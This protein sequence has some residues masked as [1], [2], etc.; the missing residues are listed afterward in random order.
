MPNIQ[1][2]TLERHARLRW[3]RRSNYLFAAR[4]PLAPLVGFEMHSAAAALPI[5]F[6]AHGEGWVVAAIL[7]VPPSSNF[8]VAP[9]GR[10]TGPYIP[11]VLRSNPFSLTKTPNGQLLLCI[12]EDSGLVTEGPQGER[13]FSDDG[14]PAPATTEILNFLTRMEQGRQATERACTA[15]HKHALLTP[16]P[17]SFKSE[18]GGKPVGGLFRVDEPALAKL[19]GEALR[20]LMQAGALALAYCQLLS[21]QHFAKLGEWSQAHAATAGAVAPV[22]AAVAPAAK[23][24]DASPVPAALITASGDLNLDFLARSDTLHFGKLG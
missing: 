3:Q 13:F 21:M 4:Q 19:P 11:A 14:K 1:A 15:L 24:A 5:A 2:I 17:V 12:D 20:E 7:G 9:D 23:K 18:A 22:A 8:C 6:L 10:W 16:W